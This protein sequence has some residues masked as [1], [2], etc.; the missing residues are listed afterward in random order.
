MHVHTRVVLMVQMMTKELDYRHKRL[1]VMV[2]LCPDEQTLEAFRDEADK[3]QFTKV[4]NSYP[5]VPYTP[6]QFD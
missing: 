2:V 4:P 6:P 5:E 1:K 3:Q